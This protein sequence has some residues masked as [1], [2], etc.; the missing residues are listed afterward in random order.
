LGVADEFQ[1][2]Q[3][4]KVWIDGSVFSFSDGKSDDRIFSIVVAWKE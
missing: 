3:L 4:E 1:Q 2:E